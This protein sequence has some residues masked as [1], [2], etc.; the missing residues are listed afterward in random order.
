M[1]AGFAGRLAVWPAILFNGIGAR[2]VRKSS[3]VRG[4]PHK[5]G[6]G[7]EFWPVFGP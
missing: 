4:S 2:C 7:E 6:V 5:N 3:F 1:S